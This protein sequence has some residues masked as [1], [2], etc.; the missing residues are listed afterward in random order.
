MPILFFLILAAVSGALL[1]IAGKVFFVKTD[2]TVD[3][4][5]KA[6]PGANCGGCGY[7][8]CEGY[9]NAIAKGEAPTNLCKPG[10][11]E[12]NK[13]ISAAMG[14]EVVEVEQEVAFVRCNGNCNAT[15]DKYIYSGTPSCTA[16]E[17]FYNGKGECA[18]GCSGFGDCVNVCENGAITIENGVAVVNPAKCGACGKCIKAC[19][20]NLITLRK[21]SQTLMV[22]CFSQDTGKDT[23]A[24]CKNGCIAC[25][26][27]EKKCPNDAIHVVNNHAEIDSEK[28]TRC[29]ICAAAC[30]SKCI[31]ILQ[32][33]NK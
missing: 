15:S 29:G 30:P 6:L 26:I 28:C 31:N 25:K 11:L 5:L 3:N 14:V 1:T 24:V 2:E 19:P 12:A 8:G 17:K 20:N 13:K 16:A 27:C 32:I 4:I 33:C 10:G 21:V 7:S 9:A 23:R 22:R 18:F